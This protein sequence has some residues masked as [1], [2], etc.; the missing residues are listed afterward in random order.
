VG[1]PLATP[2]AIL[3]VVGNMTDFNDR[4]APL[5]EALRG[6]L[7]RVAET[8]GGKVPLHG[9]LFAQ[10]LHFVFP[11]ECAFPH[12]AGEASFLTPSQ[13]GDTYMV[14]WDEVTKHVEDGKV[15]AAGTAAEKGDGLSAIDMQWMT[16]W[17][18]EEELPG[19]Y[20]LQLQSPWARRSRLLVP[21]AAAAAAGAVVT[22][23]WVGLS[24][25][26]SF[27]KGSAASPWQLGG[28]GAPRVHSV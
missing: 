10:W 1:A 25:D 16:Q 21:G 8:H 4:P 9:R 18:E 28:G 5:D 17:S 13:F 2:E 27:S 26:S 12:R 7:R 23:L 22:L 3:E 24:K 6:Q 11:R 15:F 14:T 20:S 19:D